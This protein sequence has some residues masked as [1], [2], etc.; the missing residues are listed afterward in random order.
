MSRAVLTE[1]LL[2]FGASLWRSSRI[3]KE[4]PGLTAGGFEAAGE[5]R[6][7]FFAVF[8]WADHVHV[9]SRGYDAA[10]TDTQ[11]LQF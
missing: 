3:A 1:T 7:G 11:V 2:D 9:I 4:L 10:L 6:I 5:V 8:M